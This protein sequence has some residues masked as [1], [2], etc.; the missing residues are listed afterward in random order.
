MPRAL[1]EHA[2]C[3]PKPPSAAPTDRVRLGLPSLNLP[4]AAPPSA[5]RHAETAHRIKFNLMDVGELRTYIGCMPI[6]DLPSR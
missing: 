6:G 2:S 3:S 4:E 5:A 1:A